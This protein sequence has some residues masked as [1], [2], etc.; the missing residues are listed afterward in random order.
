MKIAAPDAIS[1]NEGNKNIVAKPDGSWQNLVHTSL[2]VVFTVTSM[3]T[4]KVFRWSMPCKILLWMWEENGTS[5]VHK[6]VCR[7]K[8]YQG[9]RCGMEV[10]AAGQ[11]SSSQKKKEK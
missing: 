2:N 6:E 11:S 1:E 4:G 7:S 10:P 3:D 8:N 5:D 9:S